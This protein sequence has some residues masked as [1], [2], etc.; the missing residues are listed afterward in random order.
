MLQ[1]GQ[2]HE[3][4]ARQRSRPS[5]SQAA[6]MTARS[7]SVKDRTSRS[8]GVSSRSTAWRF[9]VERPALDGQQVHGFKPARTS[10]ARGEDWWVGGTGSS[11]HRGRDGGSVQALLADHHEL[12]APRRA[13]RTRAGRTAGGNGCRRLGRAGA[14]ACPRPRRSP[15]CAARRSAAA[16]PLSRSTK[17]WGSATGARSSTNESKSSWSCSPS[18][19]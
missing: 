6:A 7:V 17:A 3:P 18:A 4:Q 19:S 13:E 14:S 8:A 5:A 2:P 16:T 11:Q 12:S 1:V 15:S 9:L 10:P